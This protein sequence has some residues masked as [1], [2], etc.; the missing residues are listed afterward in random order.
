[1]HSTVVDKNK[2]AYKLANFGPVYYLNMDADENRK[3]YMEEQ[4]A[5]WDVTNYER[6]SAY[7]GR[8][9]DLSDI[10]EGSLS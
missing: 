6:V 5:Y 10:L 4:F 8:D 9:D 2:S 7:D 3:G 1:M